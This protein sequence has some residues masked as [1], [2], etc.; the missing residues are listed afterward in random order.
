M[1]ELAKDIRNKR[2][3]KKIVVVGVG[4]FCTLS[5]RFL[6]ELDIDIGFFVDLNHNS[7]KFFEY[8]MG[9]KVMPYNYLDRNEHFPFVF[10][11]NYEVIESI[12]ADL[13][14]LGFKEQD[15]LLLSEIANRDLVYKGMVIGKEASSYDVLLDWNIYA[16]SIGRYSSINHTAQI[17]S[18]HNTS[19][20]TTIYLRYT[21][22]P[23]S[24]LHASV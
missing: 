10:Q 7:R 16:K 5:M 13:H 14:K 1:L 8:Q 22:P 21:P 17:V 2:K 11:R 4:A 19:Y 9:F 6:I 3:G 18:D 12:V 15:Y 20:L 24:P 23:A